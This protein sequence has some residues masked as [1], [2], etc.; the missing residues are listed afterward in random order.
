MSQTF[1]CPRCHLQVDGRPIG[2]APRR[3]S[4]CGTPLVRAPAPREADVRKYLYRSHL[5]PLHPSLGGRKV[6]MQ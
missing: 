2:R 3:C 1:E 5:I 4:A 6:P